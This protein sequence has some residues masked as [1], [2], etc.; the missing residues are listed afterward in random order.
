M[1]SAGNGCAWYRVSLLERE[2]LLFLFSPQIPQGKTPDVLALSPPNPCPQSL[3]FPMWGSPSATDTQTEPRR[4]QSI[5]T[6]WHLSS[7]DSR[8]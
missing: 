3:S 8:W 2:A 5:C 7:V 4:L 1:G 6:P